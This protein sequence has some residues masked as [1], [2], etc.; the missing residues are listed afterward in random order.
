MY[1][2]IQPFIF[3]AKGPP[4]KVPIQLI[5]G[6]LVAILVEANG[7]VAVDLLPGAYRPAGRAIN[8]DNRKIS[9]NYAK[10]QLLRF[11]GNRFLFCQIESICLS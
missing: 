7:R 1:V 9:W 4:F 5:I 10:L 8:L 6:E 3:Q 11:F 2:C